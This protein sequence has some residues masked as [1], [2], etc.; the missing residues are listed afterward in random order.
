ML[1]SLYI[2]VTFDGLLTLGTAENIYGCG[3]DWW[4]DSNQNQVTENKSCTGFDSN[5]IFR[6][7]YIFL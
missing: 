5:Q 2:S 1:Y 7:G 6:H 4:F 3:F